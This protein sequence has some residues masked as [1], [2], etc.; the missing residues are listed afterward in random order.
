MSN[1]TRECENMLC[2]QNELGK[3]VKPGTKVE[4]KP[5]TYHCPGCHSRWYC[6][7]SCRTEDWY[8]GHQFNCNKKPKPGAKDK[9][10][11]ESKGM[12]KERRK[13]DKVPI[14]DLKKNSNE[15]S[16]K[17][18]KNSGTEEQKEKE[19][20]KRKPKK[21]RS[22]KGFTDPSAVPQNQDKEKNDNPIQEQG[23]EK[24]C[25]FIHEGVFLE[26]SEIE[27]IGKNRKIKLEHFVPVNFGKQAV[28]GKGSYGEVK[29]VQHTKTSKLFAMKIIDKEALTDTNSYMNLFKEIEIHKR[30]IHKN[31]IRL[32]AHLEDLRNVYLVIFLLIFL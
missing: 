6:S 32:H 5:A 27:E 29:L 16:E 22:K 21:K 19:K 13:K 28:L 7:M 10:S 25:P 1:N 20:R 11:E 30:L 14:P 3:K 12:Q 9:T 18:R 8:A 15:H 26:D 31:I 4:V 24:S 23:F 17:E 2:P